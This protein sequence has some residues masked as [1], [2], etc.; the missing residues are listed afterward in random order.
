MR[1]ETQ[2]YIYLLSLM[3]EGVQRGG[4][5]GVQRCERGVAW[6]VGQVRVGRVPLLSS[7]PMSLA[8]HHRRVVAARMEEEALEVGRDGDV[9]C[10]H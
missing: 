7:S 10:V 4:G 6:Q 2:Q 1:R 3:G 8:I 5:E 9:H